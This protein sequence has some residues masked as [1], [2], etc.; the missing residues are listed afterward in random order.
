[1]NFVAITTKGRTVYHNINSILKFEYEIA[2]TEGTRGALNA[3]RK[4][5]AVMRLVFRHDPE[6]LVDIV[7][8]EATALFNCLTQQAIPPRAKPRRKRPES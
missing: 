1:M 2:G 7:G 3:L 4:G 6:T 8:D 5:Q